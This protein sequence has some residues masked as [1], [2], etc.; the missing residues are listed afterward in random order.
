M[1]DLEY[2][3][4]ATKQARSSAEQGGFPAGAV[5]VK[6]GLVV[7]QGV[8]IG[9]TLCDPTSHGEIATIRE[10][11]NQ[12][13]TTSLIG[14]TLYTSMEP[15]LMCFCAAYWADVS[16]IVYGC[17]RTPE[18]IKNGYYQGT[19]E[20]AMVNADNNRKIQLE[21]RPE[22]EDE[23]QQLISDWAESVI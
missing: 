23:V 11:C 15:C 22:F 4:L 6:D 8:S 5:L 20:I 2:L 7:A 21:F 17:R 3:A 18:M 10:A 12:L 19:T 9:A 16:R 13:K 1:N 14:A